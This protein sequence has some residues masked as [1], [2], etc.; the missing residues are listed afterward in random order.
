MHHIS[1][2]Y[3]EAE[4]ELDYV[5]LLANTPFF[6]E[7]DYISR[8]DRIRQGLKRRLRAKE[9]VVNKQAEELK[10]Q[11]EQIKYLMEQVSKLAKP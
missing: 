7:S 4:K 8:A 6:S 11:S 3:A 2:W 9:E 5:P 1:Y 10:K